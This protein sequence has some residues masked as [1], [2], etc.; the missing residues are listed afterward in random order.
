MLSAQRQP[1][2]QQ[3]EQRQLRQRVARPSDLEGIADTVYQHSWDSAHI[4]RG[5]TH[6]GL[7]ATG[8]GF[9]LKQLLTTTTAVGTTMTSVL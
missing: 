4:S 6:P 2:L 3:L 1:D 9:A 7:V 8:G 5:C